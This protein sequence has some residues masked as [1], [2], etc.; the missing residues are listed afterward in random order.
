MLSLNE[1]VVVSGINMLMVGVMGP[2]LPCEE[3]RVRH[4]GGNRYGVSYLVQERGNYVL[5]VKWGDQHIPGS[6]FHVVVH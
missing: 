6:P 2:K 4:V 1:P 3:V 5:V